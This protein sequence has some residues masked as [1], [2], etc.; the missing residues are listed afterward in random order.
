MFACLLNE[1]TTRQNIQV[2][3]ENIQDKNKRL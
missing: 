1:D 2:L 3:P